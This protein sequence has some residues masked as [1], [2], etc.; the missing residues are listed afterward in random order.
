MRH[1]PGR[2]RLFLVTQDQRRDPLR[3]VAQGIRQVLLPVAAQRLHGVAAAV[4]EPVHI[5]R[6]R[7]G[8]RGHDLVQID[9]HTVFPQIALLV[10]QIVNGGLAQRRRLQ[11]QGGIIGDEIVARAQQVENILLRIVA[12]ARPAGKDLIGVVAADQGISV[13]R[14]L[15]EKVLRQLPGCKR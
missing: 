15:G 14:E 7:E 4:N 3:G 10:R 9:V 1:T 11:S 8:A 12:A 13:R 6:R 2:H 5:L